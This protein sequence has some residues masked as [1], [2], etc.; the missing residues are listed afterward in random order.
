MSN[1]AAPANHIIW[2]LLFDL[3]LFSFICTICVDLDQPRLFKMFC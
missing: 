2:G 1:V 3:G